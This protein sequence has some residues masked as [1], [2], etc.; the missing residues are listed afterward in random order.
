MKRSAL[1]AAVA[2]MTGSL[3]AGQ[4][5][6]KDEVKSAAKKLSEMA[7]YSWKTTVESAGGGGGGQFRRGPT[8]GKSEKD[9]FTTLAISLGEFTIDAVLKGEKGAIRSPDGWRSLAEVADDTSQQ[10]PGRF[11]ARMLQSYR[12]PITEAEF[13]ATKAKELAKSGDAYSGN[14]TDEGA[15]ELLT[16]RRRDDSPAPRN[17][18]GSVKFWIKEGVLTKYEYRL[19][20][21]VTFNNNDIDVDRT[22]TVEI[23]EVG[24][25]KVDV[26]D[27]AKK[28]AS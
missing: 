26:P 16:F 10:N 4:T 22:T 28:K 13:L 19:Q 15:K 24:S 20:G 23:K 21:T 7:N 17:A 12:T 27:E 1:V 25:T 5:G 2:V 6:P 14:L 8:E 9:G 3:V 11:L 18:R